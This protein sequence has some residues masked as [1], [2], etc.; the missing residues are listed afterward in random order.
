M[1]QKTL[2]DSGDSG[3]ADCVF[4]EGDGEVAEGCHHL[5]SAAGAD[6]AV[7]FVVGD[8]SDVVECLDRPVPAQQVKDADFVRPVWAQAGH[9]VDDFAP[10]LAVTEF[11]GAL[12]PVTLSGVREAQPLD[13]WRQLNAPMLN[14]PV[15]FL[16]LGVPGGKDSSPEPPTAG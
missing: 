7:V 3:T 16:R 4:D 13:V 2:V 5:R 12:D 10:G 14:A 9:A 15:A 8:V 6:T 1:H 11:G